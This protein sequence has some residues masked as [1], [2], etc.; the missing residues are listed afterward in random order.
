DVAMQI[1][2]EYYRAEVLAKISLNLSGS[3][4]KEKSDVANQIQDNSDRAKALTGTASHL[5]ESMI[6][7]ALDEAMQIQND[8]DR[9][10]ALTKIVP[11]NVNIFSLDSLYVIWMK[12]LHGSTSSR[13]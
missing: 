7:E 13:G 8:S 1:R 5:P 12:I 3:V 2:N 4:L 10:E 9:A 6:K 11:L